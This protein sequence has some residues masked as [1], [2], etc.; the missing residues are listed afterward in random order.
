MKP[1][2]I[3]F[4]VLSLSFVLSYNSVAQDDVDDKVKDKTNERINQREDEGI[5][6]GL[7]GVEKGVGSLFKK[8]DKGA[9][10]EKTKQTEDQ[11]KNHPILQMMKI[12]VLLQNKTLLHLCHRILNLTLFQVIK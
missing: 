5:D 10:K 3:F 7:D 4:L 1:K 9:K 2:F 8:K 6:K 12:P 11:E